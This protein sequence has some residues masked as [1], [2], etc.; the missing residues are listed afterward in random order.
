MPKTSNPLTPL[1]ELIE[2]QFQT[3]RPKNLED[4]SGLQKIWPDLIGNTIANQTRLLFLRDDILHV[5]VKNSTWHFELTLLKEE[6][7]LKINSKKLLGKPLLDVKF[8]VQK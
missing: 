5:A 2:K 4:L 3:L 7:L 8:I 1:K 6:L